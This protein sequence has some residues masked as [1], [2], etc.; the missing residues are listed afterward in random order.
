MTPCRLQQVLYMTLLC[1]QANDKKKAE[2][3]EKKGDEEPAP[4]S[5]GE[6]VEDAPEAK[7]P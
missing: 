2:A 3:A 4:K 6:L 5:V 1:F 7:L